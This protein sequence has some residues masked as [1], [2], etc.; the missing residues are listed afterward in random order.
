[1]EFYLHNDQVCP[2]LATGS[3]D[4]NVKVLDPLQSCEPIFDLNLSAV[5][6]DYLIFLEGYHFIKMGLWG[7]IFERNS[8]RSGE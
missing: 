5:L 6:K 3:Y 4:G 1:M 7:K 8:R 2:L